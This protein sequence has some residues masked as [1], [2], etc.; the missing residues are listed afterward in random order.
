MRTR[1]NSIVRLDWYHR[2]VT[3]TILDFQD[4]VTG[5]LPSRIKWNAQN[6]LQSKYQGDAWVRDNVYSI[7]AVWALALAYR[8]NADMDEDRAKAYELT[9][10][11]VKC[12]RGLLTSMMRQADKV[13][14]FKTS[15]SRADCL[16]AKY[17]MKTGG[18]C[19]SD[20]GWGHLQI[21][22]TSLYLLQLA[23]MTASGIQLIFT[24]DEVAFIQNLVFYIE[25][26]YSVP[27]YGI[28]ERG[29]KLNHGMPELNASSIGL[30][31][32]ALESLNGMDLFGPG[33]SQFSV[34]HVLPDDIQQCKAI[35]QSMLP[36]E[37]NSKEIAGSLLSVISYPAFA[38]EDEDLVNE[39]RDEIIS[40]LQG[41]YG[42]CR[43]LRDGYK[44]PVEDPFRLHYEPAELEIFEHIE[45]E[46]PLF[47]VYLILD[48][49]FMDKPDQVKKYTTL[50][51]PL[52]IKDE[53]GLVLMPELFF[54]PRDKVSEEKAN[55]HSVDRMGGEYAPHM[56]SQSLYIV[57]CLLQ[58]KFVAMG[59]LD[60]LNR[61]QSTESRPD[62]VVQVAL[63][64][65][66]DNVRAQL[67]LLEV[68]VQVVRQVHPIQ[69]LPAHVLSTTYQQLG[70]NGKL[71]MT[72]RP[73]YNIGVL[74]T[75]TLYRIG[76]ALFTFTPQFLD[77]H[78]FYLCLDNEFLADR[79]KSLVGFLGANWR[80]LGRP[81]LTLVV[82]TAMMEESISS[83]IGNLI[84]KL[85]GGYLSGVRVRLGYLSDFLST[86]CI[87]MLH[88]VRDYSETDLRMLRQSG[89]TG[90]DLLKR[91]DS[92]GRSNTITSGT[93][94]KTSN[95]TGSI[96]RSRSVSIYCDRDT[97]MSPWLS[98]T[99]GLRLRSWSDVS[100]EA[101]SDASSTSSIAIPAS[102]K[103]SLEERLSNGWS[104]SRSRALSIDLETKEYVKQLED[105][106]DINEQ[107]DILHFL[108]STKG[109][110]F[111][112]NLYDVP[113]TTVEKLLEELYEK[114]CEVKL[115]S[116]VRHTAGLLHKQVEDLS[117]AC[118]DILVHQKQITVGIPQDGHE[119]VITR[120]LP[121]TELKNIIYSVFGED[122]ST[123]VVTQ[124]LLVYLGIF[125][126][127]EPSMF[128]EMLRLR[129]GL[130]IEVMVAELARSLTCT[131]E[132][133]A[134]YFMNL[135]PFEMK[136]L[137]YHILSGKEF[138]ITDGSVRTLSEKQLSIINIDLPKRVGIK[139]LSNAIK[140]MSK[141]DAQTRNLSG[142]SMHRQHGQP[143]LLHLTQT[144]EPQH[145]EEVSPTRDERIGTW[146]RRRCLDGALN[147]VPEDFYA[148]V[149]KILEKC[150]QVSIYKHIL[151]SAM[152]REMTPGELKFALCV[153]SALNRIPE[154]EYRQLVVEVLMVL[155]LVVIS[156]P[157]QSLWDTVD[158]DELVLEGHQAYL[159]EQMAIGGNS[160]LCCARPIND[161]VGCGGANGICRFF[162]DT[163]PS[164]RYGT[165]T[166]FSKAVAKKLSFIPH[167]NDCIIS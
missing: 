91:S 3:R 81:I 17:S 146:I 89:F 7:I 107:A 23:Q 12:M 124:E 37:S 90:R 61:R 105:A 131:G 106:T 129:V 101:E 119:E 58:E 47:F 155:A 25:K 36:R 60:P 103:A 16:H 19:V 134:E 48:G 139:K 136:T 118:T 55:P 68:P 70:K 93:S 152:V 26:A 13:E 76:N 33:G 1:S 112:T 88:F 10:A 77:Y 42:L 85:K 160:V 28:W 65:E 35:L 109:A 114:A 29:D 92:R 128:K 142:R 98:S 54:V 80:S 87:S 126:R 53:T 86:S 20:H 74:G 121:P 144:A 123:G 120:P 125:V 113:E 97:M 137:L 57:A 15:Q 52:L 102:P 84:L 149:W 2:L 18:T 151:P 6:H 63:L 82:T 31:K 49:I 46:W 148:R 104:P 117:E 96:K 100:T 51:E 140:K 122:M 4:P 116:L 153:E 115:W 161:R 162:Y 150:H 34:I 132:D 165:M 127:T 50:L 73:Y 27:D 83:C 163:A 9:Q 56:W 75:S 94:P 59:E 133:A 5:L 135:S 111:D 72:G 166:Y 164:G 95:L 21:D 11:V 145:E 14:R 141:D 79:F 62:V 78:Q 147:R 41:R 45:C 24:L 32:A 30:A 130:I 99:R 44:T 43:F 167:Q 38:V 71:E 22:A 157:Q 67:S 108:Y 156:Y 69:V 138:G 154:P 159:T 66:D 40:K 110:K 39:T 143:D 8:K 158:V 64:A